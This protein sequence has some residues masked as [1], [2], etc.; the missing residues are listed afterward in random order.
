MR[1]IRICFKGINSFSE[2]TEIDFEKLTRTGIFG[3]FGDTGSGKSTILDCINFALYGRVERSNEK[4][5]IINYH[6]D[7]AEVTFEFSVLTD[8]ERRIYKVERSIRKKSGTHSATLYEN[9]SCIAEKPV[10]VNKKVTE[11]LGVGLEDFRKCIALPQG[12]FAQFVKSQP[13][14]R[15]ALIERLFSL[16]KYGERFQNKL[17]NKRNEVDIKY[18]EAQGK[19]SAYDYITEDLIKAKEGE[20]EE[21]E[22][23]LKDLSTQKKETEKRYNSLAELGKRAAELKNAKSRLVEFDEKKQKMDEL[24]AKFKVAPICKTAV[25]KNDDISKVELLRSEL[26]L[27]CKDLESKL[28]EAKSRQKELEL[29]AESRKYDEKIDNCNKLLAKYELQ[30][31]NLEK[32]SGYEKGINAKRNEYREK[33]SEYKRLQKEFEEAN[34]IYEELAQKLDGDIE[35]DID[36]LLDNFKNAVLKDEYVNN[37]DYFIDLNSQI[38]LFKDHSELYEFLLGELKLRISDYN[39]KLIA[40]KDY[41]YKDA[42]EKLK[43]LQ[44]ANKE[45]TELSK[46]LRDAANI[47]AERKTA[48]DAAENKLTEIKREGENLNN[49]IKEIKEELKEIFGGDNYGEIIEENLK[50]LERYKVEREKNKS[51]REDVTNKISSL[52]GE[53][54]KINAELKSKDEEI[55][56]AKAELEKLISQAG[57]ETF[58]DCKRVAEE[59]DK[60]PNLKEDIENFG[61]EYEKLKGKID[62][63]EKID[64]ILNFSEEDALLAKAEKEQLEKEFND[65]QMKFGGLDNE[66]KKFNADFVQKKLLEKDKKAIESERNLIEQL[67]ELTKSNK[68]MEYIAT[69]Y[70]YD[71]SSLASSTLINLTDGRYF[72]KYTDNFYVGDNFNY[73]ELR[74][75]NTLSGGETFL[76]S[77]SLALALSQTICSS[78]KSIEFFFLDEGFGTLDNN[79]IDTVMNALEKLKSSNFTI[80]IISHVEELK[81]RIDNKITVLKATENRGSSV[82]LSC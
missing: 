42:E 59:F 63:L 60:S 43:K 28:E 40:V 64:G 19:L 47:K 33:E 30:S 82:V 81:H 77:L 50:N 15:I 51:N 70:L 27:S 41:S 57:F 29:Q 24:G 58:E 11:I 2:Q 9:G 36:E 23:N 80:G 12:E 1:P 56:K 52:N 35:Q 26:S 16:E 14:E 39:E 10:E 68:F 48:L 5:D 72:L 32:I 65:L 21:L 13:S 18:S 71:I 75:V 46:Q 25:D 62:E 49:Q 67:R 44:N 38:K 45:K 37:L 69:E 34:K 8:G 20:K 73:G 4:S 61:R 7:I 53:L 3:I 17:K 55:L 76:V 6:S 31:G 74:G 54:A 79:L 66:L 22:K 78:R